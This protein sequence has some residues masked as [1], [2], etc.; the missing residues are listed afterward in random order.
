MIRE[1]ENMNSIERAK[2]LS[3]IPDLENQMSTQTEQLLNKLQDEASLKEFFGIFVNFI[4]DKPFQEFFEPNSLAKS[5]TEAI[6]N[7]AKNPETHK[8]L[9]AEI[10]KAYKESRDVIPEKRAKD[11]VPKQWLPVL[12]PIPS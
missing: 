10:E 12:S 4:L 6:Q 9:K 5:L 11:L 2:R 3:K 1:F 8:W 7:S